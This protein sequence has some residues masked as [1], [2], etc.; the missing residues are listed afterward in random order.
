MGLSLGT[1]DIL[2]TPAAASPAPNAWKPQHPPTHQALLLGNP[3]PRHNDDR[4]LTSN[5]DASLANTLATFE[6]NLTTVVTTLFELNNKERARE[7]KEY[8]DQRKI[9]KQ[10]RFEAEAKRE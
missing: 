7:R 2:D 9:D 3:H 5:N 4:S 1:E 8:A 6:T 10:Q